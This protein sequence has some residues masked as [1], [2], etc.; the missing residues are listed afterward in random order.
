MANKSHLV[1][2]TAISTSCAIAFCI[3]EFNTLSV[4]TERLSGRKRNRGDIQ[5]SRDNLFKFTA[6]N[7]SRYAFYRRKI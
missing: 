2:E 7:V 1:F 5:K 4:L 6:T 3:G